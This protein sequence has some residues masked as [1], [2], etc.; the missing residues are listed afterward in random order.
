[1]HHHALTARPQVPS[2]PIIQSTCLA[3]LNVRG[4]GVDHADCFLCVW[5]RELWLDENSAWRLGVRGRTA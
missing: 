3:G 2:R 5:M 1:V 4:A